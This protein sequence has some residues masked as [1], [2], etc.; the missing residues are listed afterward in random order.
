MQTKHSRQAAESI[1]ITITDHD[2]QF[3]ETTGGPGN[4]S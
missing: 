2:V 4:L 1:F 3:T